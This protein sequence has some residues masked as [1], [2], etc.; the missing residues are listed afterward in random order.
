[1][2][3]ISKIIWTKSAKSDLQS[4]IN[5][6][7][8]NDGILAFKILD[9]F[10]SLINSLK[11]NPK[12]GRIVPELEHF[13]V[14]IYRELIESPWRIFYKINQ[15][16]LFIVAIIDGRRNVEDILLERLIKR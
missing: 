15:D 1:M 5:Y 14:Y 2:I 6:I 13:N 10:Y 7:Y 3:R 11:T 9:D 16:T 4:I 8:Q 12:K